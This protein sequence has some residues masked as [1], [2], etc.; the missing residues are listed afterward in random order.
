[1]SRGGTDVRRILVSLGALVLIAGFFAVA[2]YVPPGGSGGSAVWGAITGTLSSQTDLNTALGG[3][4]GTSETAAD[5]S[6][7][8]G[9]AAASYA[10]SA[11]VV[12]TSRTV[13]GHA[14]SSNVSIACADLTVTCLTA[15][16]ANAAL[17]TRDLFTTATI[18]PITTGNWTTLGSG[19]TR[20]NTTGPGGGGAI[21]IVGTVGTTTNVYGVSRAV[22]AGDFSIDLVMHIAVPTNTVPAL[23]EAGFTDG[24]KVEGCGVSSDGADLWNFTAI[25]TSDLSGGTYAASNGII[26][27]GGIGLPQN[28]VIVR[29][30][31]TGTNLLCKVSFNGGITFQY[32]IFNDTS[33]Y[34]TASAI[35][36]WVDPR[37]STATAVAG[38][39]T[40]ISSSLP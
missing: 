37:N 12:P 30:I 11:N 14:L 33:P 4:L 20:T 8:G 31:R 25:K 5:S 17:T 13:A 32:T 7:L 35:A 22:S 6:K 3:K 2:Q 40:L 26:T 28:P 9:T 18:T 10:L 38:E 1:M 34:L 19:G 21:D 15:L 39:V 29:L 36:V 24:T 27:G 16:P 23:V